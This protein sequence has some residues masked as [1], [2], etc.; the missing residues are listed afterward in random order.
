[1]IAEGITEVDR[2]RTAARSAHRSHQHG[3]ETH[4]ML[5]QRS[6]IIQ[7]RYNGGDV[8]TYLTMDLP[9][10][11]SSLSLLAPVILLELRYVAFRRLE[12][13]PFASMVKLPQMCLEYGHRR[14]VVEVI[15]EERL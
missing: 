9:L 4:P 3:A 11:G 8:G 12:L 5:P 15:L 1:M 14:S 6:S 10:H 13:P 2:S 7:R